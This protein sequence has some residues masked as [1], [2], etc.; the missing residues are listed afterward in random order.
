MFLFLLLDILLIVLYRTLIRRGKP[1]PAW[2]PSWSRAVDERRISLRGLELVGNA[3]LV[4]VR[5]VY[6][7]MGRREV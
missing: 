4:E 2:F 7:S 3:V 6:T 5:T 1:C